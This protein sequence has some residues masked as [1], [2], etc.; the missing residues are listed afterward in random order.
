MGFAGCFEPLRG[1]QGSQLSASPSAM[2]QA[3]ADEMTP[4]QKIGYPCRKC[5]RS[6]K[7]TRPNDESQIGP[8]WDRSLDRPSYCQ[9]RSGLA[10]S[11]G[12]PGRTIS[13]ILGFTQIL[14]YAGVVQRFQIGH[15]GALDAPVRTGAGGLVCAQHVYPGHAAICVSPPDIRSPLPIRIQRYLPSLEGGKMGSG[16]PHQTV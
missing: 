14:P 2:P 11:W 13:A 12:R 10:L 15:L 4:S 8:V 16:R 5:F 3:I 7:G 6:N 1:G 9:S